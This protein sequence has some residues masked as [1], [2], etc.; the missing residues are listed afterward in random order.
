[1]SSVFVVFTCVDAKG[2]KGGNGDW[3]RGQKNG[4]VDSEHGASKSRVS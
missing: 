3:I 2:R 4:A 1:M